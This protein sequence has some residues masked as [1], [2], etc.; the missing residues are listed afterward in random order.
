MSDRPTDPED[1][2]LWQ[3]KEDAAARY[4]AL[5]REREALDAQL[6]AM[7]PVAPAE[8]PHWLDLVT[9]RTQKIREASA[10]AEAEEQAALRWADHRLKSE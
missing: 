10:A 9:L 1:G 5:Q 4:E 3:A 6:R 7:P 8:I 2:A